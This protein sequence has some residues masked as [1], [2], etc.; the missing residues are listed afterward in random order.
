[1]IPRVL[2][3]SGR[4]ISVPGDKSLSHRSVLFSVLSKGTSRVSGFL[5]A[6]DPLNTMKAFSHLGLK[7]EKLS[8][9]SYLFTSPGKSS[10]HS[11][12]EELDFGNAG[13]GI[14]L[15]AG[16]LAGL[17]GINARLTGDHS[18]QK[19]PMSR[20]IKP[21]SAM[22]ASI[23]GKEDKAPLEIQGK[24]LSPFVYKSPIASAQVKSCLMLAAMASET[25]LEYEEEILSRD[26][27]E[28]MFRFLGNKLQYSS[29]THF[30]MEPPYIFEAGDFKVPGDIS[31]AAFFLVLGVL[32]KEGS[33]LVKNVGLNPSRVGILKAL[34][35]MGAK[36]LIHN[37][38]VECGE[39]VGDLEAVSSNLY[40]SD[41]PEEWIPS[42]ID[43]IP[44]LTIA[45]L[46]AKGGFAIR[47]AEE[48]RAKESDRITAMVENLR[49][50]GILVHEYKDG[51]EIPE[52]N[53]SANSSE[54]QA[55]LSGKGAKISTKMDHR[56]AMSFL[57]LRAVSG[58]DLTPDETSWIETSFPGFESLLKGFLS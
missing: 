33:V 32:L 8:P 21:L 30:K 44:I 14:R 49:N 10:L 48:L 36:I 43:E 12:K 38:R 19:R 52:Q 15:S 20:I 9:G 54:L 11:P 13:T 46:F 24:K 51:Y 28:N 55:W 29:P 35:A 18:L 53:S 22:G 4:E 42:L 6:E 5:E 41:I 45:G 3:S 37:E 40:F 50:L 7:I 34:E 26:H 27:T 47:H 16:L 57:V 58:L 1:M 17:S 25:S 23:H 39:P 2:S 31:S 56:I